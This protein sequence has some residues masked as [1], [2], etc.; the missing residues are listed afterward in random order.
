MGE[1]DD[2]ARR[3]T[4][5][6]SP[7]GTNAGWKARRGFGGYRG[8]MGSRGRAGDGRGPDGGM[9]PA[10]ILRHDLSPWQIRRS[11]R[12]EIGS[13]GARPGQADAVNRTGYAPRSTLQDMGIDFRGL[14]VGMAEQFLYGADVRARFK[15]MGGE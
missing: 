13:L 1:G 11:Y 12:S 4:A 8:L 3:D 15:Q 2:Y 14:H 7:K 5:Q 10:V 6:P 9:R